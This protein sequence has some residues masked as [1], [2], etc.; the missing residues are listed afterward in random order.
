MEPILTRHVREPHA[1]SLDFYLKHLGYEALRKA[2][3]MTP[4]EVIEVV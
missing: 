4:D 1:Y 3:G 2:L